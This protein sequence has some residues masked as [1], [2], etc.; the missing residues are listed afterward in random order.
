[1]LILMRNNWCALGEINDV[2]ITVGVNCSLNV[3]MGLGMM[4]FMSIANQWKIMLCQVWLIGVLN[5][6]V[7]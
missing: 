2:H 5:G 7:C 6:K 4:L 3:S 1:M